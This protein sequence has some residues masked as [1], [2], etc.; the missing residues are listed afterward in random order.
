MINIGRYIDSNLIDNRPQIHKTR[1]VE[2]KRE[3]ERTQKTE[4]F[5]TFY[6]KKIKEVENTFKNING[7]VSIYY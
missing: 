3:I 5:E 4:V 2:Q 7:E 6:Q 1:N